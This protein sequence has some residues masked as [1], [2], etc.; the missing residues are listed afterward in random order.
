[1]MGV[2]AEFERAMIQQRVKAGVARAK[3]HGVKFGRPTIGE[4]KETQIRALYQQGKSYRATPG[5]YCF[6]ASTAS[7]AESRKN[8]MVRTS[9][10]A[11]WYWNM[12]SSFRGPCFT[13]A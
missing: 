12:T 13:Y 10:L 7:A 2:F 3:A 1:M 6:C 4:E 11:S 5:P 8:V 9:A